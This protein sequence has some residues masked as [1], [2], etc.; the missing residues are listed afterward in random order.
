MSESDISYNKWEIVGRDLRIDKSVY[1]ANSPEI[2]SWIE[3][4][5]KDMW[6][7]YDIP[8]EDVHKIPI[9][10]WGGKKYVFTEQFE[11]WFLLRWA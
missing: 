4:H 7:H 6:E 1:S 10:S 11:I 5:D 9:N 8:D 2:A 3:S